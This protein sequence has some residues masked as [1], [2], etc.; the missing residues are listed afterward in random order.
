MGQGEQ[1]RN[2]VGD[3]IPLIEESTKPDDSASRLIMLIRVDWRVIRISRLCSFRAGRE[4]RE[5]L[6]IADSFPVFTAKLGQGTG[7]GL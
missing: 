7:L 6:R 2:A 5:S 1:G 4:Y 3:Q